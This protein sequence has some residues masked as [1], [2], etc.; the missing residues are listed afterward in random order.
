[1]ISIKVARLIWIT[2]KYFGICWITIV[3]WNRRHCMVIVSEIEINL[4]VEK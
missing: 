3:N 1:M 4:K 2:E